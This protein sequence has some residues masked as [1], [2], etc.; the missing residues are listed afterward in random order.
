[1]KTMHIR[2]V[3][4]SIIIFFP[5]LMEILKDLDDSRGMIW[6]LLHQIYYLPIGSWL[7]EP[8]FMPDS[9]VSFWVL[10]PGRIL[11]PIIYLV[12]YFGLLK[13][14]ITTRTKGN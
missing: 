10:M 7:G 6:F 9:E 12:V 2:G 14:I 3:V 4:I 13:L 11:M 5:L 8:F 1:M